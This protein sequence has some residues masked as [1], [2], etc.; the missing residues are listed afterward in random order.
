MIICIF[1]WYSRLESYS[2][3]INNQKIT[4]TYSIIISVCYL[5]FFRLAYV[6]QN[7][8]YNHRISP[9]YYLDKNHVNRLF[10]CD[11]YTS[12]GDYTY[13]EDVPVGLFVGFI[14]EEGLI[15]YKNVEDRKEAFER[16]ASPDLLNCY[17]TI[18]GEAYTER[19]FDYQQYDIKGTM[20]QFRHILFDV[21]NRGPI[22]VSHDFSSAS[23][24]EAAANEIE[25]KKNEAQLDISGLLLYDSVNPFFSN[26]YYTTNM[27]WCYRSPKPLQ[28][29]E[30]MDIGLFS[31]LSVFVSFSQRT[32]TQNNIQNYITRIGNSK[33]KFSL[34]KLPLIVVV[35]R[36]KGDADFQKKYTCM[37]IG[38]R[39]L[40]ENSRSYNADS[41]KTMIQHVY[42]SDLTKGL[43]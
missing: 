24:L 13:A 35:S 20:D 18:A 6:N 14:E 26:E 4:L 29:I 39:D 22:V 19:F 33:S 37:R 5:Y 31:H 38:L 12:F 41:K 15:P 9:Y 28:W 25:L 30:H 8:V 16:L 36:I 23:V 43:V 11:A 7:I 10:F 21:L 3:I 34:S 40:S 17:I 42:L 2:K 27:D 1:F 32:Q